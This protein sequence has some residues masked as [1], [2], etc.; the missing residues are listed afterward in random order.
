MS[1]HVTIRTD[2]RRAIAVKSGTH[3]D[4]LT[5]L[6]REAATLEEVRHPNVV[7]FVRFDVSDGLGEMWTVF[8]GDQTLASNPPRTL[9]AIYRSIAALAAA[10]SDIH[11]MGVV[12]CRIAPE[13]V[14]LGP[15]GRP[16]LC[17][18]SEAGSTGEPL[19]TGEVR[20]PSQDIADLGA[21]M[22]HIISGAESTKLSRR[23]NL[24]RKRF[25]RTALDAQDPDHRR[26]PNAHDIAAAVS[27]LQDEAA[28]ELA[29][30]PHVEDV[31]D[32]N[33]PV[34]NT[35]QPTLAELAAARFGDNDVEAPPTTGWGTYAKRTISV[36]AI[37]VGAVA[38]VVGA[39]TML[40]PEQGEGLDAATTPAQVKASTTAPQPVV[41]R[42]T[43]P[44][45]TT[46]GV[47]VEALAAR[48]TIEIAGAS[49]QIGESGDIAA[50]G[51]WNCDGEE[52]AAL[53]RPSSGSIFVF[54]R[55]A[56]DG[57]EL[58]ATALTKIEGATGIRAEPSNG[59]CDHLI[60][61]SVDGDVPFAVQSA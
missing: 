46:L 52:T 25:E 60:V 7:E 27:L 8:A 22:Q 23:S 10:L 41:E 37:I 11:A 56:D 57:E 31:I 59:G 53:L 54:E 16:V 4:A 5:A 47:E 26:R 38:I 42:T 18:F 13:H 9:T 32:E 20:L 29:E 6:T 55:W 49:Y 48:P 33:D 1:T 35:T 17:S 50:T 43:P 58:T 36:A 2:G 28:T 61:E 30:A 40:A 34:P 19:P 15:E 45:T 51:D 44:T 14:V 39:N 21:L 12:H 24:S 3:A